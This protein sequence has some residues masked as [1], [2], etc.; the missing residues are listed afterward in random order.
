MKT[1]T[2]K[3]RKPYISTALLSI[4]CVLIFTPTC[5]ASAVPPEHNGI[6]A[7]REQAYQALTAGDPNRAN[8]LLESALKEAGKSRYK[9]EY[10]GLVKADMAAVCEKQEHYPEAQLLYEEALEFLSRHLWDTHPDIARIRRRLVHVL[11]KN[12][13]FAEEIQ[14][15]E[16]ELDLA[17]KS[18]K[19]TSDSLPILLD[20]AQVYALQN[21]P[22]KALIVGEKLSKLSAPNSQDTLDAMSAI[23]DC[24]RRFIRWAPAEEYYRRALAAGKTILPGKP[25][26][27]ADILYGLG[28]C[29][30]AQGKVEEAL[31][32][33]LQSL[34]LRKQNLKPDDALVVDATDLVTEEYVSLNRLKEAEQFCDQLAILFK[35]TNGPNPLQLAHALHVCGTCALRQGK[36]PKAEELYKRSLTIR[37]QPQVNDP[38]GRQ[39]VMRDLTSLYEQ[40]G[41]HADAE[42]LRQ[43]AATS[44]SNHKP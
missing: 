34:D 15:L 25:L 43:L 41:K 4:V 21:K 37:L 14:L 36:L 33:F 7:L 44:A 40:E 17:K 13:R 27:Q 16:S 11:D 26:K 31:K 24:L 20:L 3:I 39:S 9:D 30:S 38:G 42:R 19:E 35:K 6:E 22:D 1:L 23:A 28:Y 32:Y 8:A 5:S 12:G 10:A 29:C 2:D 18:G